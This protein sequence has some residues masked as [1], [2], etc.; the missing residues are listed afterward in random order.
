[1][2]NKIVWIIL[3]IVI[4]IIGIV[5]YNFFIKNSSNSSTPGGLGVDETLKLDVC[6][7]NVD[8]DAK[9]TYIFQQITYDGQDKHLRTI[10]DEINDKVQ[11]KYKE[12]SNYLT[13]NNFVCANVA[14]KYKYGM[15][16]NID[17][18]IYENKDYI[19]ITYRISE[20]NKCTNEG[21]VTDPK[22]YIYS[23]KKEKII[24]QKEFQKELKIPDDSMNNYIDSK[25]QTM[26]STF[27][28]NY[29]LDYNS[30]DGKPVKILFYD[31]EGKLSIYFY[32]SIDE[33]Y[34]IAQV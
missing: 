3:G 15:V 8:C 4:I 27:D 12:A 33:T 30:K 6:H 32:Q 2:K 28:K 1:M 34:Q 18:A 25:I 29:S 14:D 10:I 7:K 13:K 23:K 31:H 20:I 17:S 22:V 19:S 5:V 21:K 24:S 11:K 26:N 16:A 9:K